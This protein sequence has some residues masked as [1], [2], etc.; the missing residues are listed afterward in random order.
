M[1]SRRERPLATVLEPPLAFWCCNVKRARRVGAG[2]QRSV[3]C[4]VLGFAPLERCGGLGVPGAG[5]SP[6][7][8][9]PRP[10]CSPGR[11]PFL[12]VFPVLD[13]SVTP[14]APLSSPRSLLASG[15]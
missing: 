10:F 3:N 2:F 13:R 5:L 6:V 12:Q 1:Y 7:N 8:R 4:P 11:R 9:R 15:G 14:L